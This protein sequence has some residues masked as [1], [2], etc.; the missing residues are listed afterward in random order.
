MD[1]EIPERLGDLLALSN[2]RGA[3]IA[4]IAKISSKQ[5]SLG[6]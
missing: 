4:F 1:R 5:F 6:D 2:A 3:L